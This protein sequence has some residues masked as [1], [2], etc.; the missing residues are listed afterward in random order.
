MIVSF[1]NE[2]T[3]DVFDGKDSKQARKIPQTIWKIV[4]RKLD[5][6]NGA[7]EISKS[8]SMKMT[9]NRGLNLRFLWAI[10]VPDNE[11]VGRNGSTNTGSNIWKSA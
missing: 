9:T 7:H 6:L 10:I 11:R 3:Q 5:M 4:R 1:R 2:T 8:L